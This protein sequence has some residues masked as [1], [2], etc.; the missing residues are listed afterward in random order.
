MAHGQHCVLFLAVAPRVCR[1]AMYDVDKAVQYFFADR[2]SLPHLH[3]RPCLHALN[4][5][6]LPQDP[7]F[8][9]LDLSQNKSASRSTLLISSWLKRF[10]V[11][12]RG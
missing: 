10:L 2:L 6:I 4:Q 3:H 9:V 7:L 1:S 11:G 12:C 5:P 8:L